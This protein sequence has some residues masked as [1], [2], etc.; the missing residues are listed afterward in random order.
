VANE[1]EW[2]LHRQKLNHIGIKRIEP[3]MIKGHTIFLKG[4]ETINIPFVYQRFTNKNF[5]NNDSNIHRIVDIS[6]YNAKK[7]PVA[8][9]DLIVKPMHFYIDNSFQ[10]FQ[11][12]NEL[13]QKSITV[14]MKQSVT[15]YDKGSIVLV[16]NLALFTERYLKCSD[17][18]V[19]CSIKTMVTIFNIKRDSNYRELSFKYRLGSAPDNTSLFFIFYEDQFCTVVSEIWRVCVHTIF[20]LDVN[21]I[22]GQTNT[23]SIVLRG[24]SMSRQFVCY[25]NL[26]KEITV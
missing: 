22:Y 25:T 16:E 7:V 12:E 23:A 3:D 8:Y 4:N 1:L 24:S 2:K 18:D 5:P 11:C 14:P 10:I 21:C 15:V 20:R 26:P 13:V 19:I 17:P 6:F 9:L